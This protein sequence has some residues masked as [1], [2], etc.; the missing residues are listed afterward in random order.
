MLASSCR[1]STSTERS[2]EL[3]GRRPV[4]AYVADH[5]SQRHERLV[6]EREAE[7]VEAGEVPVERGGHDPDLPGQPAQRQG[8]EALLGQLVEGGVEQGT[9][10]ALL[11]L[12]SRL[13]LFHR[14]GRHR[15]QSRGLRLP[16]PWVNVRSMYLASQDDGC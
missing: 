14:H 10:G 15:R 8:A 16:A 6:D 11:A 7:L 1:D 5:R 9:T 12:L 13:G 4:A 2:I 3:V